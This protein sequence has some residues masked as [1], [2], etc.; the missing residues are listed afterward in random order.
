MMDDLRE[1]K[2]PE[3]E[4]G[5]SAKIIAA[6]VVAL[7]FGAMGVYGYESGTWNSA[8]AKVATAQTVSALAPASAIPPL[9]EAA[10]SVTPPQ[11]T[12]EL[13]PA[14][15][16]PVKTI[17]K[18]ASPQTAAEPPVRIARAKEFQLP[19]PP[20]AVTPAPE[21]APPAP[22]PE[23]VA[24]QEVA[25]PPVA[26]PAQEAPAPAAPEQPAEPAPAQ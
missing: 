12:A 8:P 4:T 1:I 19:P 26:A 14:P 2:P 7:G 6:V 21:A 17:P 20:V 9:P 24:P 25:P 15:T 18:Q 22:T 11:T 3:V 16:P 23:P 13:P 10:P 5:N